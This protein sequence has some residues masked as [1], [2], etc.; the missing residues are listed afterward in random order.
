MSS[1][2]FSFLLKYLTVSRVG[3]MEVFG[4]NGNQIF[5]SQHDTWPS[6]VWMN[7][8]SATGLEQVPCHAGCDSFIFWGGCWGPPSEGAQGSGEGHSG[9]WVRLCALEQKCL[10]IQMVRVAAPVCPALH[11]VRDGALRELSRRD[12]SAL[13]SKWPWVCR[14]QALTERLVLYDFS[15]VTGSTSSFQE[16]SDWHGAEIPVCVMLFLSHT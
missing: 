6:M 9:P 12:S 14:V 13:C 16:I 10:Q 3:W 1:E 4:R 2:M 15:Q 8:M 11:G 7:G 5:H